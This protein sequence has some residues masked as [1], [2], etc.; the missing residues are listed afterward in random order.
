MQTEAASGSPPSPDSLSA[1]IA[2]WTDRLGDTQVLSD[3]GTL[4]RYG[5]STLASSTRPCAV[6]R[7]KSTEQV[8]ALV[9]IAGNHA[10]PL[11]PISRGKNWGYGDACAPFDG[12]AIVDLKE[13]NRI[14]EL[15]RD[16]AYCVLEPGVSQQQ[17]YDYLH[18]GK[19][20]LWMDATGAGPEASVVGN[21]LERGFGHTRYGDRF[22]AT[23]GMEVVLADGRILNTGFGHFDGAKAGRAYPYGVGPYLDGLFC[24]SNFGIVTKMGLWLMPEPE[25]FNFFYFQIER[26]EGLAAVIDAL[27]KLR[28]EGVLTSSVHIGND[29]RVISSRERYPWDEAGGETPLP[30]ALRQALRR[31]TGA[32]PWQ[33]SGSLTGTAAQVRAARKAVKKALRGLAALRF[34]DE[35]KLRMAEKVT[36]I[37]NRAG[38]AAATRKRLELVRA[39][40]DLLQGRPS[41]DPLLGTQWR[42]REAPADTSTDPLDTG[43]GL[44]WISPVLPA[45][46]AEA[47]TVL[48]LSEPIF[49]RFGF[50]VLVSFTFLTERSLVAIFN[51]AYDK[52]ASK[53]TERASECYE[54]LFQKFMDAGYLPYRVGLESMS[55]LS[56]SPSVFW[57]VASD[58]KRTFDPDGIISPGRYVPR[59]GS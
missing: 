38:M 4:D 30:A 53:E 23:C 57:D 28:L 8:Q 46:G 42:L 6:L 36:G 16:L 5:R 19:A 31:R 22:L 18:E 11:Y 24:Q 25:A 12:A 26:H 39:N 9:K 13:M 51:I 54:E 58:L 2:A 17:L 3:A 15:N 40:F 27:R 33:G 7:P 43:C 47:E 48:K 50:D 41:A 37:L 59:S 34:L 21:V 20:G 10:I 49:Q 55:A 1:A 44:Y 45:E 14:H 32:T 56:R 29:L 35:P 52:S